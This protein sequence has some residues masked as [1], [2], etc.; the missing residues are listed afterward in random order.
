[1]VMMKAAAVGCSVVYLYHVFALII[2]E[3]PKLQIPNTSFFVLYLSC[4][5]VSMWC[6]K[7]HGYYRFDS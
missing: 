4:F 2:R 6:E 3:I 1:M 7:V 5:K